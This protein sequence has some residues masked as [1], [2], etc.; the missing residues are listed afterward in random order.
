LLFF[1]VVTGRGRGPFGWLGWWAYSFDDTLLSRVIQGV[2][3]SNKLAF[4]VIFGLSSFIRRFFTKIVLCVL[5]IGRLV[6]RL[7]Y[8]DTHGDLEDHG[9]VKLDGG[10]KAFRLKGIDDE[11]VKGIGFACFAVVGLVGEVSLSDL[12][13]S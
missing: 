8:E 3:I 10:G 2:V 9:W 13:R 1:G 5:T 7:V 6:F 11:L 4:V 12:R